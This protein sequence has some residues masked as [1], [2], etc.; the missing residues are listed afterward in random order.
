MASMTSVAT[1]GSADKAIRRTTPCRMAAKT[2]NTA[3]RTSASKEP[4]TAATAARQCLCKAK[5]MEWVEVMVL[6]LCRDK[7]MMPTHISARISGARTSTASTVLKVR[8]LDKSPIAVLGMAH[9]AIATKMDLGSAKET[10]GTME[11]ICHAA[12]IPITC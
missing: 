6:V 5:D 8:A 9:K 10:L 3:S 1:A 11:V 4:A 12:D 7:V 2:P